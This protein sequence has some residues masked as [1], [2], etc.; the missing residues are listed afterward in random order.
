MTSIDAN[1]EAMLFASVSALSQKAI[2]RLLEISEDDAAAAVTALDARLSSSG[3]GLTLQK[4]DGKILLVTR[5]ETAE[6]VRA[7]VKE[8]DAGELTRPALETLTIL[9]YRGPLTR[10]EIEQ[11]RGVQSS[12]ILRNLL[13]RGLVEEKG[14]G[15]LGQALYGLTSE[16]LKTLGIGSVEEL[17]Q[18]AEL[19]GHTSIRDVLSSLEKSESKPYV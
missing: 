1:I 15:D 6:A 11:I 18:Y 12:L 14:T 2:A 4:H 3:S 16:C 8:A 9:A 7:V 19:R 13:I 10:P 17:P 5:S